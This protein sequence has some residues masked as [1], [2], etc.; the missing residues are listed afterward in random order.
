MSLSSYVLDLNKLFL[1]FNCKNIFLNAL[2]FV[3]IEERMIFWKC[4]LALY[5]RLKL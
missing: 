4:P 2:Y 3:Y 5:F 1:R